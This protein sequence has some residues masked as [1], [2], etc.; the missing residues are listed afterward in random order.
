MIKIADIEFADVPLLLAPMEGV[1]DPPFRHACKEQGADVVYSEFVSSDG[2]IRDAVKSV[3]KLGFVE[4]ERIGG[5]KTDF[6]GNWMLPS[7]RTINKK[8]R[9]RHRI[10]P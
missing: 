8:G 9:I 5:L 4:E 6:I 2:L 7:T 3:R 10:I 1:T